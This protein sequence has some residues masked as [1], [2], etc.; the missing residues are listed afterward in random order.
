[1]EHLKKYRF[2]YTLSLYTLLAF[3]IRRYHL[4]EVSLWLDESLTGITVSS[5]N[6]LGMLQSDNTPAVYYFI[7]RALCRLMPCDEVGLRFLSAIS[8]SAF[9]LVIMILVRKQTDM[10]TA[11]LAGLVVLIS[12]IHIYYS[13]EARVYSLLLFEIAGFYLMQWKIIHGETRPGHLVLFGCLTVVML[14]THYFSSLIVGSSLLVFGIAHIFQLRKITAWYFV[15][16]FISLFTLVPSLTYSIFGEHSSFADLSWIQ[17]IWDQEHTVRLIANTMQVFLTGPS[18]PGNMLALKQ[19]RNI[20]MPEF[21]YQVSVGL[22]IILSIFMLIVVLQRS[23]VQKSKQQ[24]LVELAA[25]FV[26]PLIALLVLSHAIRPIYVVGRYD[27][28][29][30]PAFLIFLLHLIRTITQ[31]DIQYRRLNVFLVTTFIVTTLMAQGAVAARYFA[32]WPEQSYKTRFQKIS[33]LMDNGST[34]VFL[35]PASAVS[36]YYF[37]LNGYSKVDH[38]CVSNTDVIVN[39][40]IFPEELDQ[41][42]ASTARYSRMEKIGAND[43]EVGYILNHLRK[44]QLWLQINRM[45]KTENGFVMDRVSYRLIEHLKGLGFVI[46]TADMELQLLKLVRV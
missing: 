32:D 20:D 11:L 1:M 15:T 12:P 18:R 25:Q 37:L 43:Y 10:R 28:I 36:L 6:W 27:L 2:A 38:H 33:K 5:T 45:N 16:L 14:H 13:Q 39:C 44:D 22:L 34:I 46:Q 41:A 9:V 17:P 19:Y 42:P 35:G 30:Y 23:T 8:G 4:G 26:L 24:T 31:K 29:A 7:Q 21:F 3:I 40:F